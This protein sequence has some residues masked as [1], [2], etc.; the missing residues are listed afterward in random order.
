MDLVQTLL[1]Q[2]STHG[3]DRNL[4][5]YYQMWF[6]VLRN[7]PETVGKIST[8]IDCNAL[9]EELQK[10]FLKVKQDTLQLL[11]RKTK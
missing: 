1:V 6:F 9:P 5:L 7:D 11:K 8:K 2:G 3:I 10:Q 4:L